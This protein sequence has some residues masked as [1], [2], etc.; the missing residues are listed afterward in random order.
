MMKSRAEINRKQNCPQN[1]WRDSFIG[2]VTFCASLTRQGRGGKR[3][4]EEMK[5]KQEIAN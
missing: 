4:G 1:N 5:T 3:G 2:N